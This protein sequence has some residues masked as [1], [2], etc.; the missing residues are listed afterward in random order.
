M[1]RRFTREG[2]SYRMAVRLAHERSQVEWSMG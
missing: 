2:V 1:G